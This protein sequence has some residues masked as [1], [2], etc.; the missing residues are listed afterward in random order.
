MAMPKPGD[1]EKAMRKAPRLGEPRG[2]WTRLWRRVKGCRGCR[3]RR[4]Q[5]FRLLLSQ[6]LIARVQRQYTK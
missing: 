2:W 5:L 3:Q 6:P 4:R 1:F